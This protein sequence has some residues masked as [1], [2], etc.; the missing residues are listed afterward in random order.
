MDA[1]AAAGDKAA[2]PEGMP[3]KDMSMMGNSLT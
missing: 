3:G 2:M 1:D